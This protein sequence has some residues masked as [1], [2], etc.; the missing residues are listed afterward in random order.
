M[1]R[2]LPQKTWF[3]CGESIEPTR[4]GTDP[5][6]YNQLTQAI[7]YC[8][9]GLVYT[10]LVSSEFYSGP[11]ALQQLSVLSGNHQHVELVK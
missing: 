7:Y 10:L 3:R 1:A 8:H 5:D 2:T 11:G 9:Q 6:Q 4:V